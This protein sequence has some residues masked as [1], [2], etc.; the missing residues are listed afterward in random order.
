MYD[1]NIEGI[2]APVTEFTSRNQLRTMLKKF[3]KYDLRLENHQIPFFRK[4]NLLL[5]PPFNHI[6]GCDW[7]IFARK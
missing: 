1:V 7:Y 5:K 6:L 3:G 2:A 4:R